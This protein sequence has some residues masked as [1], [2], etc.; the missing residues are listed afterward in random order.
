MPS[1][2]K[3]IVT[4]PTAIFAVFSAIAICLLSHFEH[5]KSIKPSTLLN[6]YLLFSALFDA[7]QLRTLW[8]ISGYEALA[9]LFS[10]G[11]AIKLTILTL[12]AWEKGALLTPLYRRLPPEAR[13]GIYNISFF[14]W[15]NGLFMTGFKKVLAFDDLYS[16]DTELSS[17]SLAERIRKS[18]DHSDHRR[19]HAL[20]RTVFSCLK[21]QLLAPILPRLCMIGFTYSQPFMINRIITFVENDEDTESSKNIGYGLIGAA[22]IIYLGLAIS[23]GRYQ[24]RVYRSITAVRGVLSTLIYDKT[25]ELHYSTLEDAAPVTLMSTDVDSIITSLQQMHDIWAGTCE[26]A[27]AMYLL[28]LSSGFGCV[29]PIVL[30]VAGAAGNSFW[31]GPQMRRRRP[32]WNAAIGTRIA[33]V[34]SILGDMKSLKMLGLTDRLKALLQSQRVIE[35]ERSKAVRW[36]VIW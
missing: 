2:Q 6:V 24:H 1:T 27:I 4:L 34:S 9:S 33:L 12:E 20:L 25:L 16:L 36:M 14:W 35:L 28:S 19:K 23:K 22:A 18:W 5:V 8:R 30:A 32:E 26:A 13:G 11:L 31:V 17:A 21:W 15:L 29:T 10:C 7:V 3:T